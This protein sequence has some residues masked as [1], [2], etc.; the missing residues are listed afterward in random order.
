MPSIPARIGSMTSCLLAG[1]LL[2]ILVQAPAMAAGPWCRPGWRER[3]APRAGVV[4][5]RIPHTGAHAVDAQSRFVL[6]YPSL[7][8]VS[9]GCNRSGRHGRVHLGYRAT[10]VG[11]RG[12]PWG[13]FGARV[14]EDLSVHTGYYEDYKD[15]SWFFSN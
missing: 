14:H 9:Y 3:V 8:P 2:V 15:W 4:T 11:T 12:Y 6:V 1:L 7:Q 5:G 13:W 10:E